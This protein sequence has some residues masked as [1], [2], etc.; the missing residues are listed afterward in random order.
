MPFHS[1]LFTSFQQLYYLHHTTP[2]HTTPGIR[3]QSSWRHISALFYYISISVSITPSQ[4]KNAPMPKPTNKEERAN[5]SNHITNTHPA[6]PCSFTIVS[7]APLA[8]NLH[9]PQPIHTMVF[10]IAADVRIRCTR[11]Y[12]SRLNL[13]LNPIPLSLPSLPSLT[14]LPP[15]PTIPAAGLAPLL[16][17]AP[18]PLPLGLLATGCALLPLVTTPPLPLLTSLISSS[19]LRTKFSLVFTS[20]FKFS[21]SFLNLASASFLVLFS[22]LRRVSS[23]STR[24]RKGPISASRDEMVALRSEALEED[25]A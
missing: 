24:R 5:P 13:P 8:L 14:P 23:S 7:I 16:P 18:P 21:I 19:F 20:F 22:A 12:P 25:K 11:S 9:L 3:S 6:A 2:Y 15:S 10:G 17:T 1:V 4:F